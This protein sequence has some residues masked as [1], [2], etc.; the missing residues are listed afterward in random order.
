[1]GEPEDLD[2]EGG[3][4]LAPEEEGGGGFSIG[5]VIEWL[6]ANMIPVIIAVVLSTII[7]LIVVKS[8]STKK[9]EEEILTDVLENKAEPLTSF[10]LEDFKV[11]TADIDDPHFVRL[12][13]SLGYNIDN[14]RLGAELNE[15][16][17]EIR[18]I[19]LGILNSKSKTDIDTYTEKEELK[20]EIMNA[21]NN[22]LIY[23][24]VEAIYY[25]EFVIS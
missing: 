21:I 17:A 22:K 14:K 18:D 6:L 16:T 12:T 10:E 13:M 15:R 1:M 20:V 23:G 2:I 4:E 9:S 8:Q 7:M 19:I 24:S 25:D 5:K 3:E 11:N